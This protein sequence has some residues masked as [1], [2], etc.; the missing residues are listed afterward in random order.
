MLNLIVTTPASVSLVCIQYTPI[1]I[2]GPFKER[3]GFGLA[4]FDSWVQKILLCRKIE[5]MTR[6]RG[7]TIFWQA[8][9]A[10]FQPN[11]ASQT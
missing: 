8:I 1:L 9:S 7:G 6:T 2:T 11:F 5:Q 10:V 3:R 4:P